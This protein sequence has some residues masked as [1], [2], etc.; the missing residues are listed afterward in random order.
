MGKENKNYLEER[1]IKLQA[2]GP[3]IEILGYNDK[4]RKS[5]F[6]KRH[7]KNHKVKF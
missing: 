1:E 5:V 3:K 4:S 6:L 7:A 2:M